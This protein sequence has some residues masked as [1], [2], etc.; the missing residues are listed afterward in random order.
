MQG[1]YKNH[2]ILHSLLEPM[3]SFVGLFTIPSCRFRYRSF[4]GNRYDS[5]YYLSPLLFLRNFFYRNLFQ[6]R[7]VRESCWIPLSPKITAFPQGVSVCQSTG[8]AMLLAAFHGSPHKSKQG[9][10][11]QSP[12]RIPSIP[13]HSQRS[14][15]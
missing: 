14:L 11:I 9:N 8:S 1:E 3:N 13:T 7:A 2:P 5:C 4:F 12:N 10:P 15:H 6:R